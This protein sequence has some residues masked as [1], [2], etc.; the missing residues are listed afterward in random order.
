M[1]LEVWEYRY[2]VYARSEGSNE[3]AHMRRL[4]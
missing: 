4:V 1:D 3:T 2:I